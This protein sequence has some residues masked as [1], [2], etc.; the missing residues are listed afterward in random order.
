MTIEEKKL[1]ALLEHC[2]GSTSEDITITSWDEYETPD[3]DFIVL[4][5]SEADDAWSDDIDNYIDECVLPELPEAY[6]MYFDCES[7]KRDCKHDGRGHSLS[8]YDGEEHEY[9]I[10]GEWIYIYRTN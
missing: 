5:D 2:E 7:F 1:K 6:R 3:G 10:D 8:S 4:T 9:Q